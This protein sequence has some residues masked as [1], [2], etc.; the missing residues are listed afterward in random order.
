MQA[1]E[2]RELRLLE[3]GNHA[4]DTRVCSPWRSFV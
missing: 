3:A 4:E 2:P 1:A